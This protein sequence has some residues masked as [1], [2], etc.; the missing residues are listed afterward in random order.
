MV[1]ATLLSLIGAGLGLICAMLMAALLEVVRSG[2][3]Q[4][5][6]AP[7]WT[8]IFDLNR[9]GEAVI[10]ALWSVV[11][12][13]VDPA[14]GTFLVGGLL[15]VTTALAV[16]ANSASRW[17]WVSVRTGVLINMQADLFKH[18]LELPLSFHLRH[19][20][21]SLLQRLHGDVGDLAALIPIL[22]QALFRTP[23]LLAGS[24]LLM[25]RTSV[26]LTAI[27]LGAAL[28]YV[29]L[30]F[31]LGQAVRRS[32]MKQSRSRASLL[33]IAQEALGGIR[34]VKA[35]GG[36]PREV[37]RLRAELKRLIAENVRG[38]L[39]S[40]QVP[41]A[42]NQVL[43][44]AAATLVA[45]AGLRLAADG[46]IT[47]Q[48]LVLFLIT[49][50]AMLASS[51]VFAQSII[52]TFLLSASAARV[53]ELHRERPDIP[54]GLV[55]AESF[56]DAISLEDV[57]F[58]Y[59]AEPVLRK[60]SLTIPRGSITALV[61]ASG[62]GKSTI[63]DLVVRFY[64]PTG[65]RL[66][67]DGVDIR[68]FRQ[69]S[70]RRLFGIVSQDSVLFNDTVRNNIAYGQ[71]D[72]DDE[73]V[74]EAA[75]I[76]NADEFIRA[77]PAGYDTIV[78]ERGLRLSGGQRQRIAIARAI[79][80][81]PQILVLDEATSSLDYASERA[82]QRAIDAVIEGRTAL[83]IAHRLTTVQ[84]AHQIAVI[85]DGSIVQRGRHEELLATDG[86][87]GRLYEAGAL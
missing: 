36:A 30:N 81:R 56:S 75:R 54:D 40:A 35:F 7:D 82:V 8:A 24:L 58:R 73:R 87:Y 52:S 37:A 77:L 57:Y 21:G 79:A 33:S 74:V 83:V 1:A 42:L 64:D 16:I 50:V 32:F 80:C 39:L 61:G 78:G 19:R 68:Q 72:L 59:G 48:G 41:G 70:Y 63:A 17:L 4:E 2:V 47:Q 65:G 23:L 11:P 66:T 22:F 34:V 69:A 84:R 86:P 20:A 25:L 46:V 14:G 62:A 3:P 71:P 45:I 31:A 27:T 60:V 38:D 49:A 13:S 6:R 51:A 29:G 43:S 55:E 15:L 44:V 18:L 85:D 10:K 53:L 28:A 12:P 26:T 67:L 5:G 76:A 9:A